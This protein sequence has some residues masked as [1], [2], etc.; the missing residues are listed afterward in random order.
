[1]SLFDNKT[2]FIKQAESPTPFIFLS[3]KP[4]EGHTSCTVASDSFRYKETNKTKRTLLSH[5]MKGADTHSLELGL[6][7]V[8]KLSLGT[9]VCLPLAIFSILVQ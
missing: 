7:S 3:A 9:I 1:M 6:F 4:V 2:L 5:I 8:S